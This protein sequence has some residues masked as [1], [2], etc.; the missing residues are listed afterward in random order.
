MD[1]AGE[2]RPFRLLRLDDGVHPGSSIRIAF[3]RQTISNTRVGAMPMSSSRALALHGAPASMSSGQCRGR[4]LGKDHVA[5]TGEGT[6]QIEHVHRRLVGECQRRPPCVSA[7]QIGKSEMTGPADSSSGCPA[8]AKS[9]ELR[10][11]VA[12]LDRPSPERPEQDQRE[13]HRPKIAS[14]GPG[15]ATGRVATHLADPRDHRVEQ[16]QRAD[17]EPDVDRSRGVQERAPRRRHRE[18]EA[19]EQE[20]DEAVPGEQAQRAARPDQ[21]DRDHAEDRDR[22]PEQEEHVEQVVQE[23]RDAHLEQRLPAR[24]GSAGG[25]AGRSTRRCRG[26]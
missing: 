26:R 13:Q 3:H 19:G 7:S 25:S 20:R 23:A 11:V 9:P 18:D 24:R 4:P 8:S 6:R 10:V 5:R 15:Q 12:R 1:F 16:Q 17:D 21:R 14:A 22:Q 2:A